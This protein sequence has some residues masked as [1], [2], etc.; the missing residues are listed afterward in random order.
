MGEGSRVPQSFGRLLE[1]QSTQDTLVSSKSLQV[2]RFMTWE[3]D[4]W[5]SSIQCPGLLL[6]SSNLAFPPVPL[7]PLALERVFEQ[8]DRGDSDLSGVEGSYV[9]ASVG[10]TED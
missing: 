9:V 3:D 8:A 2:P 6:G 1:I 10:R 7:F 4:S 5:I